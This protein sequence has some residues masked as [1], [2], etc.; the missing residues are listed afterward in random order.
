MTDAIINVLADGNGHA[1]NFMSCLTIMALIIA[2]E[3]KH[4]TRQQELT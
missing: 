2:T 3:S 1:S 4:R